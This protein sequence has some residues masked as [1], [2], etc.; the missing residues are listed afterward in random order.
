MAKPLKSCFCHHGSG[1]SNGWWEQRAGNAGCSHNKNEEGNA[2]WNIFVR[3][4]EVASRKGLVK[5][6]A[7]P[8]LDWGVSALS[9]TWS[10]SQFLM[11]SSSDPPQLSGARGVRDHKREE[12]V[13]EEEN[14]W[15]MG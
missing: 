13:F 9:L 1:V 11:G 8:A 12:N 4:P 2:N 6:L 15:E 10:S 7:A 14:R 5:C 3:I